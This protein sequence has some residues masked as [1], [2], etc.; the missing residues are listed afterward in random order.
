MG[1]LLSTPYAACR[2]AFSGSRNH[3][4]LKHVMQFKQSGEAYIYDLGSTHGTSVNK[5]EVKKKVYTELHVGDVIRF[6]QSSRLYVFQG[7]TELMPPEGDLRKIRSVKIREE[8]HDR[9]ASILRAKQEA[10]IA[11]GISWGMAEDAIEEA[12]D[13]AEEVTW[14]TYKGQLTDRQQKTREKVI[15]RIEK[16]ANMKK[17]IDAIRVKDIP[18]GGLTQ[19]QQTQIARNEQRIAQILEELE[20]LEETLNESIQESLGARGGKVRSKKKGA[21]MEDEDEAPSDDDEFYDRTKKP[22]TQKVGEHQSIE[23][24]DSLLDKKDA[25]MKEI[26]NKRLLI[27]E[28]NKTVPV[29]ESGTENGDPLDAYMTGLS[30]QIVLDSTMQLQ[31]DLSS[32][33]S[34]L[35]R[36]LY[37][38]RIADPSGEAA[39]KRELRVNEPNSSEAAVSTSDSKHLPAER[40]RRSGSTKLT[41]DSSPR[42]GGP[43]SITQNAQVLKVDKTVIVSNERKTPVVI[44]VAAKVAEVDSTVTE[45]IESKTPVYT[46]TKPQWL[47]AIHDT[48]MKEVHNQNASV[49][50]NN[51]DQFV[52]YK[53]RKEVL[54]SAANGQVELGLG[55]EASGLIIRKRKQIKKPKGSDRTPEVSTSSGEAETTAEDAVALLLKHKKGVLITDD[56]EQ[57]ASLGVGTQGQND[58]KKTKRVLGPEKPAFLKSN[59]DYEAWVPPKDQSG[60]GRTSLNDRFGY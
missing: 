20:S 49:D 2:M 37:L 27:V 30:S 57:N 3:S 38:L 51:S 4:E 42:E 60:D 59:P 22:A 17:E 34:E 54:G 58:N 16:I 28:K 33:Q 39:R 44:P 32:L 40:K 9:E 23:T 19:G 12:E 52:D 25:I 10:S 45:S 31:N 55:G 24:A 21:V 13:D 6:G 43:A 5:K 53:D 47:G 46:V 1:S 11:S 48:E 15:K 36:I 26:E 50:I 56:E 8:M 18:Q 29:I 35:D 14:Q 7:P 41:D